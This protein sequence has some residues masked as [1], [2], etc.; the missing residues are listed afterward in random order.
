MNKFTV[1]KYCKI[2]IVSSNL[3][4]NFE[5]AKNETRLGAE[6]DTNVCFGDKVDGNEFYACLQFEYEHQTTSYKSRVVVVLP[7]FAI[8][9]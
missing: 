3:K 8:I 1:Q 5:H 4:V 9:T 2:E 6:L 7:Y